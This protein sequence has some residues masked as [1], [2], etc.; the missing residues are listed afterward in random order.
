MSN[1]TLIEINHDYL[2][3]H[4]D[5]EELLNFAKSIRSALASTQGEKLPRGVT[6]VHQRHHTDPCPVRGEV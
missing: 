4:G 2:P 5:E 6:W 1:R 3:R